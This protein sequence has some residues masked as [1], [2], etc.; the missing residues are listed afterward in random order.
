MFSVCTHAA[1]EEGGDEGL[2]CLSCDVV[3]EVLD[4]DNGNQLYAQ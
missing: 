2:G 4:E 3:V 1:V